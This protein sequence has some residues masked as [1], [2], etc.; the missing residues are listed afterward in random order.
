VNAILALETSSRWTGVAIVEDGKLLS[1]E[2][3]ET[4]SS[5][6]EVLAGMIKE[7]LKR[8]GKKIE[9][10][11]S[12]AVSIGPGSF[13]ALRIGLLM[14][15]GI[16]LV[17]ELK[18]IPVMTLDVLNASLEIPKDDELRIPVMDAYKG[19]LFVALYKGRTRLS[20]P[21]IIPPQSL[22]EFATE[23][24]TVKVF[25]PGLSRYEAEIRQA[26]GSRMTTDI[27]KDVIPSA[28]SLALL[29]CDMKNEA[30]DPE[31]LEPL[32]LRKPDARRPEDKTNG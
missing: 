24:E 19:E 20:G 9:D 2:T 17:R 14:A 30:C 31:I 32:Y 8:S 25:G 26:L 10:M 29:A 3:K 4:Q 15:K 11:E 1:Y 6:N 7:V 12:L 27:D 28:A 13:T 5:H 23:G 16:A 18:I 22:D 21:T